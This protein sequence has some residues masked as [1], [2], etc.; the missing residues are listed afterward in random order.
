MSAGYSGRT[1]AQKLGIKEGFRIKTVAAPSGYRKILGT[2]PGKVVTVRSRSRA[3]LD[4]VHVFVT[5]ADLLKGHLPALRK[6][7]VPDGAIWVSWPKK[8]SGLA[9]DL[10]KSTVR[11]LGIG[12]GLVDV[13]VCAVDE[14]WSALKFVIP[15]RE[16]K[17]L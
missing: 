16:R 14:T 10:N 2:L 15:V 5:R 13:K 3:R 8:S 4:L 9:T 11:T 7:I 6:Q 1:L 12:H 17:D